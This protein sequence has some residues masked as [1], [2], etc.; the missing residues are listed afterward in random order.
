VTPKRM[1]LH[2]SASPNGRKETVDDIRAW[3]IARGFTDVG[4]HFIIYVDGTVAHG[5]PITMMGAHVAGDNQDNVGICLIGND[6]FSS[7]QL[8][9]LRGLLDVLFHVYSIPNEQLFCHYEFSSAK[10][11]G[12]TCPNI[13]VEDLREWYF[14][15]REAS[16]TNYLMQ[17]SLAPGVS[18]SP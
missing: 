1:T 6:R 13:K 3:H 12:K 4:Y 16:M 7:A 9:S 11:Q 2:C 17:T 14:N 10:A 8:Y 5:R 18:L 15:H